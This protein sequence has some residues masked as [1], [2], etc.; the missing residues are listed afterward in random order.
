M[1]KK[2]IRHAVYLFLAA[3]IWG[4]AFVAQSVAA[5]YIRPFTFNA[6]R[7]IIGG[8]VLIPVAV[9]LRRFGPAPGSHSQGSL[10]E[11][12]PPSSVRRRKAMH[13]KEA[14]AGQKNLLPGG[15]ICGLCLFAGSMFQ[16]YGIERTTV[17]KAGFI[18][19]FYIVLVPVTGLF[20][21]KKVRPLIWVSI[22][23]ALTGLF[24]LSIKF[25]EGLS[26]GTGDLLVLLGAFAFTA[27]ILCIDYFVR[28]VD[29]LLLSMT[30]FF[31]CG[32]LCGI[33]MFLIEKPDPGQI[34][35]AWIPLLYAGILSCGVAYTLQVI[36]QK[37]MNPTVASLILSLESVV[38][39]LSGWVILHQNLSAK[40]L[41]GCAFMFLAV[42]LT[43]LPER[44]CEGNTD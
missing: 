2:Q 19:A 41:V 29:G 5:D 28:K 13:I 10:Q 40:E 15:L 35:L 25:E 43:C 31:V 42:V 20:F 39:A 32:I 34:L 27:H 38:S 23:L 37:D 3:S 22:A 4:M 44:H 26:I 11:V 24:L 18:T 1:N 8:I 36:G 12:L 17:G 33:F 16:Q 21:H 7:C 9:A 14:A 6:I 30:Q